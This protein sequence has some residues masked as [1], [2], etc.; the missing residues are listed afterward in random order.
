MTVETSNL[1]Y[2]DENQNLLQN[3]NPAMHSRMQNPAVLVPDAM[4]ALQAL[5]NTSRNGGVPTRTLA[6]IEL[7]AGQINGC[8]V[9]VDMHSRD[10]KQSRESDERL[11]AVAPWPDMPYFTSGERAALALAE[12]VTRLSDRDDPVPDE[13]WNEASKHYDE[14]GLSSLLISIASINVWNQLN[15]STRQIVGQGK[16]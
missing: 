10:L 1:G 11:F 6:L 8:S 7:R 2:T 13:I 4:E 9:Y 15:V 5:S 12:A 16:R 3:P 14:I